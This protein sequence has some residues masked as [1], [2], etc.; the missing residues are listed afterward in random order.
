MKTITKKIAVLFLAVVM[1]VAFVPQSLLNAYAEDA[2]VTASSQEQETTPAPEPKND[3]APAPDP[4]P[5][6]S[7]SGS[8][9]DTPSDNSGSDSQEPTSPTDANQGATGDQGAD[10]S[11]AEKGD[12]DGSN[13][14]EA[15]SEAVDEQEAAESEAEE[16]VEEEPMF[17]AKAVEV[18]GDTYTLDYGDTY[19]FP[20]VSGSSNSSWS[21]TGDTSYFNS[22]THTVTN[23][24][25]TTTQKQVIIKHTYRTWI[26]FY[27]I[28]HTDKFT[29]NLKPQEINVKFMVQE[30]GATDF[31]LVSKKTLK[32]GGAIEVPDVRDGFYGWYS[33]AACK[34]KVTVPDTITDDMTSDLV[35]YGKYS[36]PVTVTF[37]ANTDEDGAVLPE[38]I[39]G[40]AGTTEELGEATLAGWVF[41]SW[42][43]AEDGSGEEYPAGD[44]V[45]PDSDTVLYAQWSPKYVTIT[46]HYNWP[47]YPIFAEDTGGQD[48]KRWSII[49]D[50]PNPPFS[51][52]PRIFRGWAKA[53][54]SSTPDYYPGDSFTVDGDMDLYA[55]WGVDSIIVNVTLHGNNAT[56]EYNG[57]EQT[58]TG[59]QEEVDEDGN[60]VF[61]EWDPVGQRWVGLLVDC[62][63][64]LANGT[65]VGS[66]HTPITAEV[67][68][69]IIFDIPV[70]TYVEVVAGVLD[71]TP[72]T[73]KVTTPDAKQKY[74]PDKT[75]TAEGSLEGNFNDDVTL[76]TTG[77]QKEVGQSENTYK[78][79]WKN[80]TKQ[81]NYTVEESIGTL[82]VYYEVAFDANGGSGAPES[83]EVI[84][85]TA[86][87]PSDKPTYSGHD[88][89][90]WATSSS[91]TSAEYQP[92]ETI[93]LSDNIT[94]YAVWEEFSY[95][96]TAGDGQTWTKESGSTADFT[97]K[98][99]T[100]DDLTFGKFTGVSVD[101]QA[102]SSS[103]YSASAGSVN[104]SLS[105][106]FL[107]TLAAGQ[108]KITANFEDGSA[109]ATFIVAEAP[110]SDEDS[111]DEEG[112]ETETGDSTNLAGL[113]GLM[114]AALLGLI[115]LLV[116]R[117]REE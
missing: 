104:L 117:R 72:A 28:D 27:P 108:H 36:S 37:D 113:L 53:A 87:L 24:N 15:E 78:L 98:R 68:A 93:S 94:L 7:D 58:V 76:E 115:A 33:E 114:A 89:L 103:D 95:S 110:V 14:D 1:T 107:E 45:L 13:T 11:S 47:L 46:Y 4:A 70:G 25:T 43:T 73:L 77:E 10:G 116:N 61:W 21:A 63:E 71:I 5:P 18:D 106:A 48:T 105:A 80:A 6:S 96:F 52:I 38:T 8:S 99:S 88:F 17:S 56:F 3:P 67:E 26:V 54:N 31:D 81:A 97:V 55:V 102:L 16:V 30:A 35:F 9:A 34:N 109:D 41:E 91:A 2:E 112:G 83:L 42:N 39:T 29:V 19:T 92:G 66:Y 84:E 40:G 75:L 74:D 85:E 49:S 51:L 50:T 82:T 101:G 23:S 65:D 12:K 111:D 90:G 59:I 79:H 62:S 20:E 32:N 44:F 60:Y 57:E 64:I 100:N 22:T 69:E 86:A